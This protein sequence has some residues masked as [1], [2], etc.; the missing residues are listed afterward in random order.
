MAIVRPH[1]IECAKWEPA[2]PGAKVCR[3]YLKP[4]SPD[5]DPELLVPDKRAPRQ[6]G[7]CILPDEMLCVEWVR[8]YG[9]DAQKEHVLGIRAQPA[10]PLPYSTDNPAPL[11]LQVQERPPRPPPRIQTAQGTIAMAPPRP[12]EPAKEID[13]HSLEALERAGVEIE[14]EAPHL[15]GGITLV[16]ARTG[17]VDRSELTF[18]EAAA[19]RLI[20]DAFPGAH[21][22]AYRSHSE[23]R[24]NGASKQDG[25]F[26]VYPLAGSRCSACGEPQRSTLGGLT[27]MNGHGGAEPMEEDPLS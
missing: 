23:V 5:D 17:R 15:H 26:D 27:C 14:L 11:V 16:P 12:F 21:V 7:M 1:G 8:R 25:P 22:T 24:P 2:S 6:V 18:R 3:Y 20:V 4:H 9:T 19:I 13:P 10:A